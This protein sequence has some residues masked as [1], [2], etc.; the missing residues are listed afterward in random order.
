MKNHQILGAILLSVCLGTSGCASYV[1]V[2]GTVK[3]PKVNVSQTKAKTVTRIE[4]GTVTKVEMLQAENPSPISLGTLV[5]G[6]L[7]GLL[8]HQ[9]GGGKG[10]TAFTIAG[11][12][13]GAVAGNEVQKALEHDRVAVTVRTDSGPE[14]VAEQPAEN[15][16]LRIGDRVRIEDNVITRIEEPKTVEK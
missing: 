7:G 14:L 2:K 10:K 3:T 16:V 1:P 15:Q 5:G 11:A 8:G 12:V 13:G 9:L 6:A 4:Y